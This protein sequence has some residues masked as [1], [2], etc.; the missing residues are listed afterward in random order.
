VS[1]NVNLVGCVSPG[2]FARARRVHLSPDGSGGVALR[3]TH[4]ESSRLALE[5]AGVDKDD[6]WRLERN[7]GGHRGCVRVGRV[8]RRTAEVVEKDV[9]GAVGTGIGDA[10]RKRRDRTR[11]G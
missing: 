7:A 2:R 3:A 5:R 10:N 11:N 9:P 8:R 4:G 6:G 1:T